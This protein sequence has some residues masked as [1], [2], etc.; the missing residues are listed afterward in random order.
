M[1]KKI[2]QFYG[3]LS[4]KQLVPETELASKYKKLR[5]SVF[6]SATIGYSLFYVCRLSLSVVKK[7]LVDAGVANE[8]Q[9][10]IIGSALFFSYAI[11]KLTNGFLAD[12]S[13]IR[14]FMSTGL[15]MTALIN[16]ILGFETTFIVFT[17]LWGLSG[18]FQSM[19]AAP[20]VV[21]LSRWFSNK[22]RG[23]YYGI[24]SAS[25]GIGKAITFIGVAFLVSMGGWNWGFWGAG[26][27]G[28]IGAVIVAL[29]LKDSPESEGLPSI[30]DY[31]NDHAAILTKDK[32]VGK[33]QLDV[34]KNPFIWILAVSSALMYISRYA[35]ESWGIFYLEAQKNYSTLEASSIVS[36]SAI[37]GIIGTVISG[38]ISD[39][40]FRGSRNFPVLM[41]GLLNVFAISLF[42][43]Y[44]DGNAWMDTF[45]MVIFGFAIGILI[46]FI[47]GLMAIDIASKKAS[48][49]AL[50]LVGVASYIGAA[51]QD[52]ISGY[53]IGDNHS[54]INGVASYDFSTAKL[55]WLGA[56][57]LS[58]ILTLFVWNAKAKD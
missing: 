12:R 52:I 11:G 45:S 19:G 15:L 32:S 39:K 25:H 3:A 56:A 30:A 6:I 10:G 35:I 48:G 5:W 14:R 46:T 28:L 43:F 23:T 16:L 18:W 55:F 40:F 58:V 31:K 20:S 24:W 33:L 50:G 2:V 26:I 53:L 49:A 41:A 54:V 4:P 17:I 7:P 9:L 8:S 47:G 34:L 13:N 42:L 38:F 44:P 27:L 36:V 37:S 22:E 29:F 1:I 51:I 57:I 21:S